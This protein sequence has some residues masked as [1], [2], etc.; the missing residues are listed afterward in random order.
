[1][2]IHTPRQRDLF[3][4]GDDP[5]VGLHVKLD[6]VVDRRQPCHDNIAEVCTGARAAWPCL[7]VRDLRAIPWVAAEDRRQLHP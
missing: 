1:M 6:R 7:V 2:T 3:G 4:E 5:L